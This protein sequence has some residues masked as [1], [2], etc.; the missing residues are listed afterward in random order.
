MTRKVIIV[1]A[2][3]GLG[4]L[5]VLSVL[6]LD[7][8]KALEAPTIIK[9]PT[10]NI[11]LVPESDETTASQESITV[12]TTGNSAFDNDV[13]QGVREGKLCRGLLQTHRPLHQVWKGLEPVIANASYPVGDGLKD[14][15][16]HPH[17]LA[18][19]QQAQD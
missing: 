13:Y 19:L 5:L 9:R 8:D 6:P 3:A 18:W 11:T 12:A 10:T 14:I 15:R 4:L 17:A 2:V 7:M 1:L 16:N